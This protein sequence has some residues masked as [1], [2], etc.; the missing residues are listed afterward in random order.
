MNPTC[1]TSGS[2]PAIGTTWTTN[3]AHAPTASLTATVWYAA[4]ATGPV[5]PSLGELLVDVNSLS[6]L[7]LVVASTGTS[8]VHAI[9]VPVELGL[10]GFAF[11]TQALTF[12]NGVLQLCN[13]IDVVVG[14]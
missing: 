12:D 8:D 5:I 1:L 4:A 11:A 7:S 2:G 3:V 10:I 6:L 9:G 14:L 13:A